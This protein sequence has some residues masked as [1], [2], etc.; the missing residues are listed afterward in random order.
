MEFKPTARV[1]K[2]IGR[3]T[4]P[5]ALKVR[6]D[7]L[8]ATEGSMLRAMERLHS[9][10]VRDT[11]WL[12]FEVGR[13]L[14]IIEKQRR[15]LSM[16]PGRYIGWFGRTFFTLKTQTRVIEP[17]IA[18]YRHEVY[19]AIEKGQIYRERYLAIVYGVK[20]LQVTLWKGFAAVIR[21]II[22]LAGPF[23]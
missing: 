2:I 8:R 12:T 13:A 22:Q 10:N 15:R 19:A 11:L 21:L 17:L 18:D 9:E 7:E 3:V 16:P 6:L 5:N 23:I 14:R 1:V 4:R 20:F